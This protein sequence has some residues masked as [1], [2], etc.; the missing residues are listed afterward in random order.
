MKVINLTPHPVTVDPG[1]PDAITFPP[2][3]VLARIR[4][5]QGKPFWVTVDGIRVPVQ[6]ISYADDIEGL[7]SPTDGVLY[8]VSR[9]TAAATDRPDLVF[10]QDELRDENGQII[11]CRALGTFANLDDVRGI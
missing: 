4:E 9:V 5:V 7:P 2:T 3:G 1:A 10:P 6:P 11:G 8:L